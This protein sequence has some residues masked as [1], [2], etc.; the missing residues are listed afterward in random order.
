MVMENKQASFGAKLTAAQAAL[1]VIL[2]LVGGFSVYT[3]VSLRGALDSAANREAATSGLLTEME[4]RV[5]K[6]TAAQKSMMLSGLTS[7]GAGIASAKRSGE[8]DLERAWAILNQLKN[9]ETSGDVRALVAE[10]GNSVEQWGRLTPM[11][12]GALEGQRFDEAT[13]LQNESFRPL[14]DSVSQQTQRAVE[15]QRKAMQESVAEA[16]TR[17]VAAQWIAI[18]L[19]VVAVGAAGFSFKTLHGGNRQLRQ[20]TAEIAEGA[21]QVA[22]AAAQVSSASQSMAQGS[23]EQAA[24]LEETSASTEEI[25]SMTQKNAGN[26]RTTATEVQNVDRMLKETN[27]KLDEMIAS[28]REINA[29]S[30]KIGRIIKVIDEIAFQT[31]IL[32]LNAA[33]EAARAGEAGMG[34]AVVADEVRNLAQRSAQ[35]AK[36]TSELIEESIVRSNE[37]K[38]K[39]DDVAEWVSKVVENAARINVLANEV[40]VGSQEQARGIDQISRSV[41][42]MQNVTQST[43]ASAEESASAG[44]MMSSQAGRLNDAVGRLRRLVGTDERVHASTAAARPGAPAKARTSRRAAVVMAGKRPG[45]TGEGSGNPFP[46]QVGF[47]DF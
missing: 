31:N 34:F 33:V 29:S 9:M 18:L 7:D 8:E 26:A 39:L 11:L 21:G 30:Q 45:G 44:E 41:A 42:Q 24:S 4:V 3:I 40:H 19:C 27:T 16:E 32:A 23:S 13:K 47:Q 43:A 28:M 5:A 10:I 12:I 36:D 17:A 6:L 14:S 35:A 38:A 22:S 25:N 2:F 46:M 37:G 1:T 20:I 15:A